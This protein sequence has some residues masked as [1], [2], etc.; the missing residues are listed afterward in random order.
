MITFLYIF[1]KV[2]GTRNFEITSCLFSL[3]QL[4]HSLPSLVLRYF[5]AI[6]AVSLQCM[7]YDNN[8]RKTRVLHTHHASANVMIK[9]TP[10]KLCILKISSASLHFHRIYYKSYA[11]KL[12]NNFKLNF[13]SHIQSRTLQAIRLSQKDICFLFFFLLIIKSGLS[14]SSHAISRHEQHAFHSNTLE[15]GCA[16]IMH[17]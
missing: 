16:E 17:L 15:P 14:C 2:A 11:L 8:S 10:L 7:K 9:S 5:E 12:V 3:H 4:T 1:S 6:K 13:L